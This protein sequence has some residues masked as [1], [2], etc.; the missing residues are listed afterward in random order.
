[1]SI[2]LGGRASTFVLREN[3]NITDKSKQSS[4]IVPNVIHSLDASH[5]TEVIIS[6]FESDTS[7]ILTIHDCFG[8]HPNKLDKLYEIVLLIFIKIYTTDSFIDKFH[9]RN[10]QSI[11]DYGHAVLKDEKNNQEYIKIKRTKH[12]IP[13]KPK[14]GNLNI[15]NIK[16]SKYFIT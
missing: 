2:S 3:L 15:N 11:I 14:V 7:P 5:L 9:D 1:M 12:Y 10:I 4:A 16:Y 8:T 13:A 6:S